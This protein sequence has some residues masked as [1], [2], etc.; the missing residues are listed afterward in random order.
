M[1]LGLLL[2]ALPFGSG[3]WPLALEW[4]WPLA[5]SPSMALA[6]GPVAEPVACN[7][8]RFLKKAQGRQ[9]QQQGQ[10]LEPF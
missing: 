8:L 4:P 9:V 5:L 3:S 1:A 2:W 6:L 7:R 10:G